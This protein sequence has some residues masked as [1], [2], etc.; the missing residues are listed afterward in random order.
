MDDFSV[1][2]NRLAAKDAFQALDRI[3]SE[4]QRYREALAEIRQVMAYA[5]ESQHRPTAN[6]NWVLQKTRTALQPQKESTG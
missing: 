3:E 4:H 5:N 2:R 1:V 6:E